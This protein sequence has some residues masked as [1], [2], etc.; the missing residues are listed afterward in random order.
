MRSKCRCSMCPAIH[1]NSRSWLRSSSTHEPSDPPPKV[2]IVS[3]WFSSRREPGPRSRPAE[4]LQGGPGGRLLESALLANR[5]CDGKVTGKQRRA[6]RPSLRGPERLFKPSPGR[7]SPV[8]NESSRVG[9]VQRS[10]AQLPPPDVPTA[11]PSRRRGE[12]RPGIPTGQVPCCAVDFRRRGP[13]GH[14]QARRRV[15]PHRTS[16]LLRAHLPVY[17]A[18][19]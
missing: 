11:R 14:S 2:V 16:S 13:D 10:C 15:P 9:L 1:I 19:W 6:G 18:S 4:A 8:G 12:R 3:V 5:D 7:A 17:A